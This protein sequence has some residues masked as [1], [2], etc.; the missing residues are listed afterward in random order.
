Y[1]TEAEKV[2]LFTRILGVPVHA[3]PHRTYEAMR[4]ATGP[5]VR[6]CVQKLPVFV[7][8]NPARVHFVCLVTDPAA[9]DIA[10]FIREH[11]ALLTHLSSHALVIVRPAHISTDAHCE[12]ICARARQAMVTTPR[13]LDD[14]T[15]RWYFDA[16][17]RIEH[18]DLRTLSVPDINRY[19]ACRRRSGGTLDP[20]YSRWLE[21]GTPSIH[22]LDG[23]LR[24]VAR[25]DESRVVVQSLPF[26][27]E[28][29]GTM[30]G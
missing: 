25:P 16:R 8:G 18:G 23:A 26:R 7:T 2:D 15:I 22:S 19:R 6:Y 3:L 27:Y 24:I 30:P 1:V 5:T 29:F 14:A 13:V 11:H 9:H 21:L 12:A 17:R 28:Q 4:Q 10:L 20:L